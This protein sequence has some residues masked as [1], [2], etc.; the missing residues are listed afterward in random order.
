MVDRAVQALERLPMPTPD[1]DLHSG[2]RPAVHEQV[3][4]DPATERFEH[5]SLFDRIG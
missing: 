4:F 1:A 2:L 5:W 3:A